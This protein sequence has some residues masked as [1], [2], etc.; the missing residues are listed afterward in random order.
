[1]KAV[2]FGLPSSASS[3]SSASVVPDGFLVWFRL[4]FFICSSVFAFALFGFGFGLL[5]W[6]L[7]LASLAGL[8]V[9]FRCS[10]KLGF[11]LGLAGFGV[12]LNLQRQRLA[13]AGRRFLASV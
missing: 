10:P 7:C 4:P 1:M 9:G 2:G 13:F 3:A 11:R 6:L 12:Y 5:C 8:A